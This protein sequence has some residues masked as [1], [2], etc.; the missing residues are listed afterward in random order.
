MERNQSKP[1]NNT[2]DTHSLSGRRKRVV[3][4]AIKWTTRQESRAGKEGEQKIHLS[5]TGGVPRNPGGEI[6]GGK[7]GGRNIERPSC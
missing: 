7:I 1:I 6:E 5:M 4:R 2:R 3:E